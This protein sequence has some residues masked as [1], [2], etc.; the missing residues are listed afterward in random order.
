MVQQDLKQYSLSLFP[1]L[2]CLQF[3]ETTYFELCTSAKQY[4]H[5]IT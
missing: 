3:N 4:T 2:L 5:Q 1:H